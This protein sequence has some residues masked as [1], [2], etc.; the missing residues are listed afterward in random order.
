MRF[1]ILVCVAV[2]VVAVALSSLLFRLG[3]TGNVTTLVVV[4][5]GGAGALLLGRRIRNN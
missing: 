1:F 5:V 2:F 4:V 3:V